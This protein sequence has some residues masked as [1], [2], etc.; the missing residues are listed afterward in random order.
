MPKRVTRA[1][2]QSRISARVSISCNIDHENA[3][4]IVELVGGHDAEGTAVVKLDVLREGVVRL[5][6]SD[7]MDAEAFIGEDQIA[8]AEDENAHK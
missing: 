8:G 2:Q 7:E 4:G 1:G 6:V 3:I 5:Q